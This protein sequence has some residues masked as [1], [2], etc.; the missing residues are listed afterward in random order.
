MKIATVDGDGVRVCTKC[1]KE[2]EDSC[3]YTRSGY[4]NRLRTDCKQC[5]NKM[6]RE[7]HKKNKGKREIIVRKYSLYHNYGLTLEQYD[8]MLRSQNGKCLICEKVCKTRKTLSVDHC[9]K[10]GQVR[11]L[12]CGKC[13]SGLGYFGDDTVLLQKA[14]DYLNAKE[15]GI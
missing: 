13:N 12:L 4:K 10:T 2:K 7:W 3:F 15:S 14:M 1:N 8:D 6:A 11:G 9:H 5:T